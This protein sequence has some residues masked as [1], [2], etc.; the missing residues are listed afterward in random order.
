MESRIDWDYVFGGNDSFKKATAFSN[1]T[2]G[3]V[4]PILVSKIIQ[5]LNITSKDV[6]YDLGSGIGNVAMQISIETGCKSIGIEKELVHHMAAL[7]LLEQCDKFEPEIAQRVNLWRQD[8][9]HPTLD[10]TNAT[11]IF[12]NNWCFDQDLHTHLLDHFSTLHDGTFIICTK[13]LFG[14]RNSCNSKK[15]NKAATFLQ[16]RE[17]IKG[18]INGVSWTNN[19]IDCFV[20]IKTG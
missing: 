18:P 5:H 14:Q 10:I 13:E 1:E 8:L 20:Y 15:R 17:S 4:K 3:E 16:Q 7:R 9:I 11:I 2:Y 12:M 6:F 19:P